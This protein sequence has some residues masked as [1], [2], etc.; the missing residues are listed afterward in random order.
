M[1]NKEEENMAIYGKEKGRLPGGKLGEELVGK[2]CGLMEPPQA[3][4]TS[5][6]EGKSDEK[7]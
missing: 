2:P 3:C 4:K 1:A 5:P 6:V 7:R